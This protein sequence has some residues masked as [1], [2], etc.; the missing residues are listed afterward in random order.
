MIRKCRSHGA[1][2]TYE[3]GHPK[4]SIAF[5][6]QQFAAIE[7]L[8]AANGSSFGSEVRE[9]VDWALANRPPPS[10]PPHNATRR[11]AADSQ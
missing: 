11:R 9:L 10:D 1:L 5:T 6:L 3:N 8:R 2:G 4:I 7:A